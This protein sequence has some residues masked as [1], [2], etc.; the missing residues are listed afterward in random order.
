MGRKRSAK[1]W[2]D[3][4]LVIY[5]GR[6]NMR[7]RT[8]LGCRS[9]LLLRAG[10]FLLTFGSVL[11]EH[12]THSR[13]GGGNFLFGLLAADFEGCLLLIASCNVE[14]SNVEHAASI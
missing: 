9:W 13:L 8:T 12:A 3:D 14:R 11:F 2:A 6:T 1:P 4:N 7:M 10:S 5:V